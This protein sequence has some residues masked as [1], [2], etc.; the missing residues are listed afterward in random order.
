MVDIFREVDEDVRRDKLSAF[1]GRFGNLLI[2]LAVLSVVAVA[3]WQYWTSQKNKEAQALGAKFEEALK[4]SRDAKSEDAE[5]A[6]G[7]IAASGTPG[8]QLVA[9]FR[10]AGE[11]AR[12]DGA[13]GAAAFDALAADSKL[14]STFRDLAKLRAGTLRVDLLPYAELKAGLESIAVPANVWRHTAREM[15]GVAALKANQFDE[16]GRWFDSIITD[17]DAP[18]VLRQR[19]DLYLALVRGGPVTVAP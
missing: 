4:A 5:K 10:Q 15:L 9:R 2:G 14:S 12:R 6:F 7:E 17:Q 3:A 13:A 8:Y 19:T 16:A 1:W 18:A 11:T